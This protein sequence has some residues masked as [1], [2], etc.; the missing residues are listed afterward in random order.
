MAPKSRY[1]ISDLCARMEVI[2]R[3]FYNIIRAPGANFPRPLN[4]PTCAGITVYYPAAECDAWIENNFIEFNTRRKSKPATIEDTLL[5][6]AT[7]ATP[8]GS[9]VEFHNV[10][11]SKKIREFLLALGHKTEIH[12]RYYPSRALH[13]ERGWQDGPRR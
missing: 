7:A 1:T 13:F 3:T 5:Q 9:V 4:A 11:G 6:I 2:E 8:V 12:L 10:A